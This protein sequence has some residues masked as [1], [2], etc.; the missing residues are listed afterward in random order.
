MKKRVLM[1]LLCMLLISGCTVKNNNSTT[2][3]ATE[4]TTVETITSDAEA[5]PVHLKKS[6]IASQP[7]HYVPIEQVGSYDTTII[8]DALK[9]KPTNLPEASIS[10]IPYWTGFVSEN[11]ALVNFQDGRWRYITDGYGYFYEE[12]IK[13]IAD[14]GF[15]CARILY[16]LSYLSNIDNPLEIN[17]V[18]L[19]SIDELISWGMKYNVHIMLS[20]TGLPGKVVEGSEA[21]RHIYPNE[22]MQQEGVLTNDEL[23]RNPEL[24]DLYEQYMIMLVKRYSDIP[25]RNLSFELLAEPAVPDWSIEN[26]EKV[27]VPIVKDIKAVSSDRILIA[28]D[29]SRQVPEQLAALGCALSLHNHIYTVDSSRLPNLFYQPT[30]PM[31]YLPGKF[32]NKDQLLTLQS[33]NGFN[34]GKVSI[35]INHFEGDIGNLVIKAD[36]Q[37]ILDRIPSETGWLTADIPDRAKALT[38]NIKDFGDLEY[39]GIKIMQDNRPVTTLVIHDLYNGSPN[40]EMPTI[41]INDDGS[42]QNM[43]GQKLDL[44]FFESEFLQKHIVAAKKYNVGF[45]MTEVGTG[46]S[47]LSKEDYI[48]Y[49]STWLTALKKNNIPW[50][51][52]CLHGIYAPK[53]A[54]KT[55]TQYACGFTE[56]EKVLGT[57]FEKNTDVFKFLKEFR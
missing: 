37:V 38:F 34:T 22:A 45:L 49:E 40:S 48:A 46:T 50:M 18:E 16:S 19:Q 8:T 57:A 15:N 33:D 9:S 3:P 36:G 11:K 51:Y 5:W 47:S 21:L 32:S 53:G 7:A 24:A 54:V 43:S 6:E 23:F 41:K 25:N 13:V 29:V 28:N 35:Y 56:I 2:A 44:D 4:A 55:D 1:M 39:H 27:M 20:I 52:N 30:W 31:E 42:T 14:E 26:Y 10:S 12:N 17:E